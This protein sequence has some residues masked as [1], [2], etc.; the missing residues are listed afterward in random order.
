MLL[1]S[2]HAA[3]IVV[4]TAAGDD[5]ELIVRNMP[6]AHP[7]VITVGSTDKWDAM[8]PDSNYGPLVDVFAPGVGIRGPGIMNANDMTEQSG[9]SV[10]TAYISA[11]ALYYMR[12]YRLTTP[13]QVKGVI[14][15]FSTRD[16]ITGLPEGTPN[17]LAYNMGRGL[18]G[19]DI[20]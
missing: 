5:R 11:L 12:L 4:V 1:T 15:A 13:Q 10:A 14:V 9:S 20:V 19:R 2:M 16:R 6:E 8:D 7:D 17:R 3:G 18:S